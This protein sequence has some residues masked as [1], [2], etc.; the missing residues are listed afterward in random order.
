MNMILFLGIFFVL[1]NLI[2]GLHSQESSRITLRKLAS[3][4]SNQ[5]VGVSLLINNLSICWL[6]KLT[7]IRSKRRYDK[8]LYNSSGSHFTAHVV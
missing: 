4:E 6:H 8:I 3:F 1:Q 5:I 7:E 2:I